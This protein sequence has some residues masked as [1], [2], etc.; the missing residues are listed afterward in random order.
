MDAVE[1]RFCAQCLDD[2]P[3]L[4]GA[5]AYCKQCNGFICS[6]PCLRQH[7]KYR[8]SK[9]HCYLLDEE[10]KSY[11]LQKG[12]GSEAVDSDSNQSDGESLTVVK[13][14]HAVLRV[15]FNVR[16]AADK[17][18]CSIHATAVLDNGCLVLADLKNSNLKLFNTENRSCTSC[19]KLEK[20]PR[21][22]CVSNVNSNEL[23]LIENGVKGIR[24]VNTVD[25]NITKTI[26]TEGECYGVTCWKR[27]IAITTTIYQT[28]YGNYELRL[29][30]YHG[31]VCKKF[32]V[33]KVKNLEFSLP[34]YL[35]SNVNG[36]HVLI[37]DFGN[38][39]VTCV[40][41]DAGVLFVHKN[42]NLL[43]PVS[44]A[45][46]ENNN[47]FIVSQRS[48]NIH[49]LSSKGDKRGV[50]HSENTM[51]FPG[52]ISF[53]KKNNRFYMQCIGWSDSLQVFDISTD[54]TA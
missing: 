30:D 21:D 38:N 7:A 53:D 48:H 32:T 12:I 13:R 34:W 51:E 27:G 16:S 52:G 18:I 50:L 17:E 24:I 19:L 37:S 41:V 20:G 10:L 9:S 33:E 36:Q 8:L 11:I 1:I 45:T 31:R 35:S 43:R 6:D 39:S 2:I 26:Q 28:Y 54:N 4:S 42:N 29:L 22:I 40:D 47:I 46:D 5:T 14:M 15:E 25:F 23:Y 3:L 49:H 44:I